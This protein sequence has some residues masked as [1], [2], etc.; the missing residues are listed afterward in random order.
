M[1]VMSM[2]EWERKTKDRERVNRSAELSAAPSTHQRSF[3]TANAHKT[4]PSWQSRLD[5]E[6]KMA[7]R[8]SEKRSKLAAVEQQILSTIEAKKR[9]QKAEIEEYQE[10]ANTSFLPKGVFT[11]TLK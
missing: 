6:S 10:I 1:E 2:R 11:P 4:T 7:A 9:A 3:D 5:K 8:L